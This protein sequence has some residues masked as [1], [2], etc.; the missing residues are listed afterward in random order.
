M[1]ERLQW[2]RMIWTIG[3][4]KAGRDEYVYFGK[5]QYTLQNTLTLFFWEPGGGN[6]LG[7]ESKWKIKTCVHELVSEGLV[8]TMWIQNLHW[9][10]IIDAI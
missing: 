3:D 8:W 10:H 6:T 4:T 9:D 7:F 5:C 1:A 2:Q